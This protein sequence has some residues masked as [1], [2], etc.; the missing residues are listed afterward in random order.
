MSLLPKEENTKVFPD[1]LLGEYQC[2]RCKGW[3]FVETTSIIT[4]EEKQR[5]QKMVKEGFKFM[6]MS[7]CPDCR[8]SCVVDWAKRPTQ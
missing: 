2:K 4:E 5:I 7:L 3:G 8:G 1:E 6:D